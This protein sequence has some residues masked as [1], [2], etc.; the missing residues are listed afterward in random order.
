MSKLNYAVF[1]LTHGRPENV[2]TYKTLR[3]SGY[4]GK[5][6]LILDSDDKTQEQY[7]QTYGDEVIIFDKKDYHDKFDIMD[8]LKNDKVVVYARNASYDIARSLNLDYF[9]EYE[10]DYTAFLYRWAEGNILKCAR[11][12]NMNKLFDYMIELMESTPVHTIALAQG[13]DL[14]GGASSLESNNYKRKAMNSFIFRVNK[15]KDD[16]ILFIG[17][18]N[19]DVNTYLH[20]G[21]KGV[22]FFQI[23]YIM[24][25]QLQTQKQS[26]GNTEEYKALRTYIKSFYSV[27][28]EPSCCKISELGIS[29]KRIHHSIKWNNAVPKI[30]N[31]SLKKK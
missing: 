5:I 23:A 20:Y 10:D 18:M 30:L 8:N 2:I 6:Y 3:K 24:L 27:M 14:M 11:V 17:R 22:I 26:G 1:I 7:K 28:L 4:T 21:K 12:N 25:N 13:G 31:E 19:D 29:H 15:N 9:F 16:D